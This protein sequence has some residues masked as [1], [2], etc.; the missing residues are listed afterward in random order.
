MN[1]ITM[2][3]EDAI[4]NWHCKLMLS[5]FYSSLFSY[6]KSLV[7]SIPFP[8]H[9]WDTDMGLEVYH[10]L[11]RYFSVR[12][13]VAIHL[14][15]IPWNVGMLT[16]MWYTRAY[17]VIWVWG[18]EIENQDYFIKLAQVSHC[19][20]KKTGLPTCDITSDHLHKATLFISA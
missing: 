8:G 5:N 11:S 6:R 19:V 10:M 12:H 18:R 9:F 2:P 13:S 20:K 3:L 15:P 4:K 16:G 14:C 1:V 17:S 7:C